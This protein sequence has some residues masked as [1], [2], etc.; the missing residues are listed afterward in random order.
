MTYQQ[1]GRIEA[2]D[3][4]NYVGTPTS[5]LINQLNTV[6]GVGN[7]N[8]GLGQPTTNLG[9][10][11]QLAVVVPQVNAND[12]AYK[13][14]AAQW[15]ALITSINKVAQHQGSTVTGLAIDNQNDLIVANMTPGLSPQSIFAN[16][17]ATIYANRNNCAAQGQ[18]YSVVTQRALPWYQS[19]T[20]THTVTFQ[21]GAD[22]VRYFF[23]AGG[24]I[25][26]TF[27]HPDGA[28]VN[29]MWSAL[30]QA[31]GTITFSAP[32]SG[33]V[34]IAGLNYNGVTKTNGSGFATIN[35]DHGYYASTVNDVG[36]FNQLAVVGPAGYVG[37]SINVSVR[38]NGTQG[39]NGDAGTVLVFTTTWDEIPDGNGSAIS[40]VSQ[41]STVSCVVKQPG[42]SYVTNTWGS[43]GINGY[44]SGQ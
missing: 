6:T 39:L 38:S 22:A 42:T 2:S 44:V 14:T 27:S 33:T 3:Y 12:A 21:G 18:S 4:N 41:G 1:G 29:N 34:N 30:A 9:S 43:V 10:T 35:A 23:N 25:S 17:L 32:N 26:L 31:C 36:I 5:I 7:G 37:S 24:Q 11:P 15:T 20:F 40:T 8:K 28:G 19:L 13:V 16:N